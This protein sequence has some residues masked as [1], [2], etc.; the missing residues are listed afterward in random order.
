MTRIHLPNQDFVAVNSIAKF[1]MVSPAT[2][3]R[4]ITNGSLGALKL[5]GGHYRVRLND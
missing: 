5:P 2:V 3:R 4:W 1:Y